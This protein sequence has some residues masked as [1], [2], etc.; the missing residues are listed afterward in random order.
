MN[1][2]VT[3]KFRIRPWWQHVPAAGMLLVCLLMLV[4]P[5]GMAQETASNKVGKVTGRLFDAETGEALLGATVMIEGTKMGAV[6]DLQGSFVIRNV[7][8]GTYTVVASMVGYGGVKVTSVVVSDNGLAKVELALKPQLIQTQGVTVEA[9]MLKNTE[10]SLLKERQASHSVSDAISSEAISRSGASDAAS[11]MMRVTGAS[12]AN[13]K[14]AVI[15]GLSDRYTNTRLNGSAL[16]SADPDKQAFSMD[17]VPTN[18]LDNIVVTKSYTADQPGNFTGGSVN[19]VTKDFPE[20]RTLTF[21]AGSSYNTEFTGKSVLT[22]STSSRDWLG[23]DDGMRDIPDYL[24]ANLYRLLADSAQRTRRKPVSANHYDSSGQRYASFMDSACKA[25]T[26]QFNPHKRTAPLNQNYSVSYGDNL[27]FFGRSLGF[28]GNLTYDRSQSAFYNGANNLYTALSG[29]ELME[30]DRLNENRGS[31][32]VLWGGMANVN[33]SLATNHKIGARY[34]YNRNGAQQSATLDGV[35]NDFGPGSM[36]SSYNVD[37]TQRTMR[38]L[39]LNGAHEMKLGLPVRVEWSYSDSKSKQKQN[40]RQFLVNY[41]V[42][43]SVVPTDT[44]GWGITSSAEP[45]VYWRDVNE[46]NKEFNLDLKV[47]FTKTTSLKLGGNYLDK[48]RTFRQTEIKWAQ[49]NSTTILNQYKGDMDAW[50]N[51]AGLTDSTSS[52]FYL[53]DT[54]LYFFPTAEDE[55]NGSQK[56]PAWYGLFEAPVAKNLNLVAGIRHER[57]DME[58]MNLSADPFGG[59]INGSA[60]LPSL[61]LTYSLSPKMNLRGAFSRTLA[62]PNI[63]EIAPFRSTEFAGSKYFYG[64]PDLKMTRITNWDLRWEWFTRT[65]EIFAVSAFY[66]S[67]VDPIE[68]AYQGS[69][70][71][72][73]PINAPTARNLGLEFEV[74]KNLDQVSHKL[75]NF[76]IGGNLTLVRS[77]LKIPEGELSQ[78]RSFDPNVSSERPMSNQ[79]PYIVNLNLGYDNAKTGTAVTLL[80]NVFGRRFFYNADGGSPDIY[81][82]PHKQIDLILSQ[83]IFRGA[84]FKASAKN[85]LNEGFE[86]DYYYIGSGAKTPFQKHD[87]GRSFSIGMSYKVL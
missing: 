78:M 2:S 37:Y 64:N 87:G 77:R 27:S 47:N 33:Y 65:N 9:K 68:I 36:F 56:I 39:Q 58:A 46:T 60:W 11:A 21:T 59:K 35:W 53:F 23:Y 32:E 51:H 19:L 18:L 14:Y 54:Y 71:D 57:T 55:Y 45:T 49:S 85:L 26:P 70:Y 28:V 40:L 43:S 66:K 41:Y 22:N 13:G 62:R 74:R 10:A 79:S 38:S 72:R 29:T 75:A 12:V 31:D 76:S 50:I 82:M 3:T 83:N 30:V 48:E 25:F 15:R 81:E 20:S 67:F 34:V 8:F 69:N 42:D 61:N 44:S 63:R 86:A 4:A 1:R 84:T 24:Q 52:Q 7:P 80:Y 73:K 6:T 5:T 17:L 16:P